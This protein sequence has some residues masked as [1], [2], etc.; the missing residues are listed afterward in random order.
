MEAVELRFPG[1]GTS[2]DTATV[3]LAGKP[4]LS[5]SVVVG[6]KDQVHYISQN[7]LHRANATPL[8]IPV[9]LGKWSPSYLET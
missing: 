1:S 8:L 5:D 6:P 7:A 3:K 2:I 4:R 9:V